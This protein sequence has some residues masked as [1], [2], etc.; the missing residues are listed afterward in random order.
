MDREV[1]EGISR[2][3]IAINYA[4]ILA[5]LV[6]GKEYTICSDASK[7]GLACVL[8]QEE[9]VVAYASWQ[10]KPYEKNYPTHDL[11]LAALVFALKIW[12][13]YLYGVPCKIFTDYQSWNYL[14]LRKRCWLEFLKDY[15]L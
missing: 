14:N 7:N 3:K 2:V 9:K 8:M 10:L 4:P 11:E 1:W 12:I 5:L 6:E 13:H 15:D